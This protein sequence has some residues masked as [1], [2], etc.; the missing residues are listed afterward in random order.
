MTKS[1]TF[2][3]VFLIFVC[4]TVPN[5]G[6]QTTAFNYQGSLNNGGTPATGNYDFEFLLYTALAGGTQVG[7]TLT[8]SSVA[9]SAGVFSVPLDFGSQFPGADRFLEIYVRQTG[10]G[11]FTPLIPRNPISSAPYSVKSLS[12]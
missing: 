1:W 6:A 11:G 3:C 8:R 5:A 7:S 10:G 12:A 4:V 9:V 2:V